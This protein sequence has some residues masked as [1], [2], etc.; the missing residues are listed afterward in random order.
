MWYLPV[1]ISSGRA[2]GCLVI[3]QALVRYPLNVPLFPREFTKPSHLI[4]SSISAQTLNLTSQKPPPAFEFL[5]T[6]GLN[7]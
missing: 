3:F 4:S 7:D 6:P 2:T 5:V 1:R